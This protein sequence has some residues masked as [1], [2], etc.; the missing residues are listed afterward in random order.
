MKTRHLLLL[1]PVMA[2]LGLTSCGTTTADSETQPMGM[3]VLSPQAIRAA[4]HGPVSF[5]DHVKP[6]LEAKCVMCHNRKTLPKHPSLETRDEAV[7]THALGTYIVPGHPEQ[8]LLLADVR[9]THHDVSRMPA[10]GQ[11]LTSA[12]YKILKKWIQEGAPWPSGRDGVLHYV[13]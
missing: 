11:R 9:S 5:V 1:L 6:V 2:M 10:V 7:R 12:E 4:K 3:E 8:S 13:P